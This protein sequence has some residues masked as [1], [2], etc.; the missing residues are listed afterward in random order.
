MTPSTKLW[1]LLGAGISAGA[2]SNLPLWGEMA[3]DT[4]D[5]LYRTLERKISAT[6]GTGYMLTMGPSNLIK[7][8]A[9]PEMVLE[10]LC[11]AYGRTS[12]TRR[13][14]ELLD[15]P[16][17]QPN[18]C[19]RTIAQLCRQGQVQGILTTN[20]DQ[21][22][23]KAL[24]AQGVAFQVIADGNL[25]QASTLPIV[26]AHGTIET[27]SSLVFT[28][29]EYYLGLPENLRNFLKTHMQNSTLVIAGYS[30][31]DIDIFPFVRALI[32]ENVFANVHVVDLKP[33]QDNKRFHEIRDRIEYHHEPAE[34]F[35][36]SLANLPV[37]GRSERKRP[38]AALIP[39]SEK[40]PAT[41][42]FG[43]ALLTL[44]HEPGSAFSI[45]FLTQDIVEE[46][47]GDLRQLCITQLAKSYAKFSHGDNDWGQREYSSGRTLLHK[48][49]EQSDLPRQK[50]ILAEFGRSLASLEVEPGVRRGYSASGFA[51]GMFMPQGPD[52]FDETPESIEFLYN[53]LRWELRAR[54]RLCFAALAVAAGEDCPEVQRQSMLATVDKLMHGFE[55]WQ[56][57]FTD[58]KTS[59]DLPVLPVFYVRYF[60]AY[61]SLIY[62]NQAGALRDLEE[63]IALSRSRG[64]YT[65]TSCCYFLKTKYGIRL[66]AGE[67]EESVALQKYCGVDEKRM[68]ASLF[69][70]GRQPFELT[71]NS[72]KP[73]LQANIDESKISTYA[74]TYII[75]EQGYGEQEI[76]TEG[77]KALSALGAIFNVAPPE[78]KS[79]IQ[80][81]ISHEEAFLLNPAAPNRSEEYCDYYH[82][83]QSE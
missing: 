78:C 1:L 75:G 23:E 17:S 36:C 70:S 69:Q 62:K 80:R 44:G 26:K 28:R 21:L 38:D 68:I 37:P 74:V 16:G 65:G 83:K 5:T 60:R 52:R 71:I 22:I 63:C 14:C 20:F 27:G 40:Y 59:D 48:L 18:L 51:S 8:T 76:V 35:L 15:P 13:L 19:H 39:D 82:A 24:A 12:I 32:A 56:E 31:N 46:E 64:F 81:A 50:K 58:S 79:W 30:G 66:S 11:T 29:E 54:I 57:Y 7:S 10:C 45:F 77:V 33:L 55:Q 72:Y 47:T 53:V 67:A 43:D 4:T 49:L 25:P 9:Y 73:P 3:Q 41:L 61:R 34:V 6:G 42:F 2:P